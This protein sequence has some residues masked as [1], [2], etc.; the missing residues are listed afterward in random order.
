[1]Y[2]IRSSLTVKEVAY[3]MQFSEPTHFGA[4]FKKHTGTTPAAFRRSYMS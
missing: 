1:V 3:E 2:L 4:F